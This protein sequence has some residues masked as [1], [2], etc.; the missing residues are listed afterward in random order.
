MNARLIWGL[1]A[2]C[3]VCWTQAVFAAPADELVYQGA[4]NDAEGL[5]LQDGVYA[6]RFSIWDTPTGGNALWSE[7]S[8]VTVVNG[9][10]AAPLG[11]V[12]PFPENLFSN[13][14]ALYLQVQADVDANGLEPNEI[15]TPRTALR[16]VPY[17]IEA[18]NSVLFNGLEADAYA[19][20]EDVETG[21]T[22]LGQA[23]LVLADS[24]ESI[25]T[26]LD[27]IELSLIELG[28]DQNAL[29]ATVVNL[30]AD[31]AQLREDFEALEADESP[32][33]VR[34]NPLASSSASGAALL[35]AVNSLSGPA[36][37]KVAPGNYDLGDSTLVL[38][39][40]VD[41][42]G[43]GIGRTVIIRNGAS[44]VMVEAGTNSEIR[45]LGF[46][47]FSGNGMTA[48][49]VSGRVA[50][51]Y[52]VGIN[53][54]NASGA[55]NHIGVLADDAANVTITNCTISVSGSSD[56][57]GSFT[58]I[59]TGLYALNATMNIRVTEVVARNAA[60]ATA[61]LLLNA[62]NVQMNAVEASVLNFD[63][64]KALDAT[65]SSLRIL[66]SRFEAS[67]GQ[68]ST[69]SIG[70]SLTSGITTLLNNCVVS[71]S[72]NGGDRF[73]YDAIGTPA[74]LQGSA[75][76]APQGTAVRSGG[77]QLSVHHSVLSGTT[78]LNAAS[79]SVRAA[80][81]QLDGSLNGLSTRFQCYDANFNAVP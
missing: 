40:N 37:I 77:A 8:Q 63:T 48:I 45:N 29:S 36:V 52:N 33:I 35:A 30:E 11:A 7:D 54:L 24:A 12:T 66:S 1:V 69:L 20:N 16:A 74:T 10:I 5:P 18:Q 31:L 26:N 68:A 23:I 60:E 51:L 76:R 55:G 27:G 80:S 4:L 17:A 49:L 28:E 22:E 81:S 34:V 59:T 41:L 58:G 72:A 50:R 44:G 47:T 61:I 46:S 3:M 79:G 6:F 78:S 2:A 65:T 42:E 39:D 73:A 57:G 14:S 67:G 9:A 62:T 21:I 56:G 32:T 64:G 15:F 53:L 71:A 19:L 75:F 13:N 25:Q 43:N 38:P 70:V